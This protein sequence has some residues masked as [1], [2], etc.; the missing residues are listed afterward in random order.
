MQAAYHNKALLFAFALYDIDR[1]SKRSN[2]IFGIH[3]GIEYDVWYTPR[4]SVGELMLSLFAHFGGCRI[5]QR[6]VAVLGRFAGENKWRGRGRAMALIR[7][8]HLE[9]Y[10]R[11]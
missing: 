7:L 10:L 6:Q 3:F 5:Y 9:V 8:F 11:R 2:P 1:H 4:A